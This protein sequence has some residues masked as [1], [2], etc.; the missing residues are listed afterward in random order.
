[1]REGWKEVT[2]EEISSKIGD[3]LHGTPKYDE[4]GEYYFIN[5]NNLQNGKIIINNTTN[6]ISEHEYTKIKKD[7]NDRTILLQIN[8]TI[9]NL[10]FYKGEKIALGKSACYINLVPEVNKYYIRYVL[11]FD[12]FQKYAL[13]YAT[14]STIKNLGLKAVRNYKFNLPPLETQ[15]KIAS[16][17][18]GY[19]DLI[20]NNLKRIK[21]LEEMAQQTYEE[22]FVRMR[23]PGHESATINSETGLPEGWEKVKLGDLGEYLNGFAFKPGD[24][25]D[26]GFPIIKIKEMKAGLSTDTPRYSGSRVPDKYFVETG[27]I[28]FSW[29]ATLDVVIWAEEKGYVNQHLFKVTPN[30]FY[31]RAFVFFSIKESLKIFDGL[32]TGATMKHIKRKELDFVI[33]NKPSVDIM[34]V[35]RNKVD[36]MITTILNLQSQNQRLR[37]ARDILLPRLMMGMVEVD[38]LK[39]NESS[40]KTIFLNQIKKEASK[41]FKEAV[42]IA[43]L[44]DRFG[45]QMYPLGRKRYTKLSYLFHRY[46]DNKIEDY[47]R[48]AAGPYNPKTKYAGPEKIALGNKYIKNWKSDKGTAGFVV[49]DKIGDAQKYFSNYWPIEDLDWLTSKFKF[50][51]NDEL[52]LYATV[53]NSLVELAKNNLD[54]T[55]KN[56]LEIIKAEKEWEAKLEREIFNEQ[57]I[58][59]SIDF[60][61]SIFCY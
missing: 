31:S 33:I 51:S 32:T 12:D 38:N 52:E 16:I 23:F 58:K 20:E 42:L 21:I 53:D 60:L 37:E 15:K 17:L 1:M 6:K 56:V 39:E 26:N 36:P 8:G 43:C 7:L 41:E 57:N 11:E 2:L 48:K 13:L 25:E 14:G 61:I 28:L 29:S 40:T 24:F 27:D 54:F 35:F 44:V 4:L 18:S 46:S 10:A 19:D 45:S 5:G 3:G 22:W 47:K 9:G 55:V 49:S 34:E 59:K 30:K 50:K